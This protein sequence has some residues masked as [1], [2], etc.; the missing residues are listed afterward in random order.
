MKKSSIAF[1]IASFC[2]LLFSPF[3]VVKTSAECEGKAECVME[4]RSRRI[5]YEKSGERRLPM[6]STTKIV[7]A[8]AVLEAEKDFTAPFVVPQKAVG[9]EGSSVYLQSGESYTTEE[10]LYGLMLRSGNDAAVALAEHTFGSQEKCY[11]A[12]NT[13]AQKAGAL[14]SN[15]LSPHGLPQEG[16]YTTARD[17]S[18][19][20]CYAL[21]NPIFSK[22]VSTEYYSPRAWKNKNKMLYTFEGAIGVKTGYTKEAGRCLVSAATRDGFTLVCTVLSCPD[23]YERSK[24]LLS[25]AFSSYE[26]TKILGADTPVEINA[27]EKKF[28]A[29]TN[30]DLYYPL[31]PNERERI[32]KEVQTLPIKNAKKGDLVGKIEITLLNRLLFSKNL[33]KL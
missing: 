32:V 24:K 12:M 13:I 10:L 28:A 19:I 31:L 29:H 1:F 16:H 9:V 15:F 25:D 33:Y 14:H 20:T 18:L 17:L 7:T 30:E 2:T 4:L 6:A 11:V 8:I 26:Y 5:L 3:S 23:T 21:H 27:N 22:I